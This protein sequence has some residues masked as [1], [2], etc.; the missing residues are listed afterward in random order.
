MASCSDKIELGS[1]RHTNN[2][3]TVGE[4]PKQQPGSKEN[5]KRLKKKKK[6]AGRKGE[7]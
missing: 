7:S 4:T 2:T 1:S 5:V 3:F 6:Y